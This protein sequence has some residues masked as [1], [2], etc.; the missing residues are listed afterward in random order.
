MSD[1]TGGKGKDMRNT[2]VWED[3]GLPFNTVLACVLCKDAKEARF[4][5]GA[6]NLVDEI[7]CVHKNL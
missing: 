3:S 6:A 2:G 4:P 7:I 1:W 5:Q